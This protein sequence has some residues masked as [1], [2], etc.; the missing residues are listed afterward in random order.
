MTTTETAREFAADEWERGRTTPAL[1]SGEEDGCWHHDA[2]APCPYCAEEDL[3]YA[4]L[5]ECEQWGHAAELAE[6]VTV[7]DPIDQ[8]HVKAWAAYCRKQ[9]RRLRAWLQATANAEEFR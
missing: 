6:A 1:K 9:E 2:P 8:E 7:N 4:R 5:K 3:W